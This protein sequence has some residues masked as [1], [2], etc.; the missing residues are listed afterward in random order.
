[1]L[2]FCLQDVNKIVAV[3]ESI[4]NEKSNNQV[5]NIS[6]QIAMPAE[7][8]TQSAVSQNVDSTDTEPT[9]T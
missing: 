9:K 2:W 5:P 3:L 8:V 6:G 4:N 7:S 1:M